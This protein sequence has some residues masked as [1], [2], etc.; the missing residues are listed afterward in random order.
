MKKQLFENAIKTIL[1]QKM[2]EAKVRKKLLGDPSC[3]IDEATTLDLDDT[4]IELDEELD[5]TGMGNKGVSQ[6]QSYKK[7]SSCGVN[8]EEDEED[9]PEEYLDMGEEEEVEEGFGDEIGDRMKN[10]AGKMSSLSNKPS[11]FESDPNV[12][13]RMKGVQ[14]RMGS[15]AD[16]MKKKL[17]EA[18]VE[19]DEEEPMSMMKAME[20]AAP[21]DKAEK[22]IKKNKENFQKRY[23][24][25]WKDVLYA[26]AS[27]MF[28]ED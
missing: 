25:K 2:K 27:K 21:S 9:M 4:T 15:L 14:D 28:P 18:E 6:F 11:P 8:E 13:D 7:E 24:T 5:M 12:G 26:T 23:G 20:E 19:D 10:V 22:F 1:K 3:G 16:K 17:G